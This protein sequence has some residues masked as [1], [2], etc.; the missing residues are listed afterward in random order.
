MC[1]LDLC[2]RNEPQFLFSFNNLEI[3]LTVFLF[4][5][6]CM[7]KQNDKKKGQTFTLT[8]KYVTHHKKKG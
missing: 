5:Y 4:I 2:V 1:V 3:S 8:K 7:L 6:C